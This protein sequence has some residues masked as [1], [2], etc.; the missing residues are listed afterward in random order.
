MICFETLNEV[1]LKVTCRGNHDYIFAKAGAFVAGECNGAKN[2]KFSKVLL[3]PQSNVGQALFGQIARR[4]TGE[5]LPLMKVEFSGD[6]I[7]YYANNQQHVVVCQL[8][9]GETLSVESENILAFTKDCDYSV[10]FLAQGV[11]SQKGLATSTL[12]GRGSEAYVAVLV[13]G[14]PIVISNMNSN[15]TLEADPD[16][17]VCW[18]GADPDFKTD[19]SWK[20]LIGQ[21]S[22]ESYMF[23]WSAYKPASVII[24]PMER[25]SGLDVSMDG[26][27][28]GS[29]PS[30]Q[31]R[32]TW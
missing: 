29:Q 6:S 25:T 32:I 17:V 5:N 2:F 30:T 27:R 24:Q 16:A 15:S 23:E 4:V 3:G 14:N 12:T 11:I 19:L 20:N 9:I 18:I 31:S 21:S 7:T 13:D 10:R 28:S 26:R 8:G 22:G 1:S